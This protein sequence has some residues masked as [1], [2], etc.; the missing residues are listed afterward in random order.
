MMP[1]R[2]EEKNNQSFVYTEKDFIGDLIARRMKKDHKQT[3]Q[4]S[5]V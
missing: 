5:S 1:S 3:Q 2:I 4:Y